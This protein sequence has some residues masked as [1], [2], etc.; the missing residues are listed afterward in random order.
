MCYLRTTFAQTVSVT[1]EALMGWLYQKKKKN[2][3]GLDL[4]LITKEYA[5]NF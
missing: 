2:L 1:E 5:H 3:L 4:G